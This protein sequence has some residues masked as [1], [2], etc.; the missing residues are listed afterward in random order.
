MRVLCVCSNGNVRSVTLARILKGRGHQVLALGS[1][2][3]VN[4]SR[5]DHVIVIHLCRWADVIFVQKDA[6]I[7]LLD[8][9]KP[10]L[11]EIGPKIDTRFDVGPDD[12]KTPMHPDLLSIM[13]NMVN[14]DPY[15]GIS[16]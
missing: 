5:E 3:F 11:E 15:W 4:G 7:D 10:L 14:S 2:E 1:K 8:I 12:W 16:V 9:I 6:E 13:R